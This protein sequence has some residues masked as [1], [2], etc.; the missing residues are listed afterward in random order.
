MFVL[1]VE[2]FE[3]IFFGLGCLIL[4]VVDVVF[5]GGGFDYE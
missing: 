4:G 1:L 3:E 2:F 5:G